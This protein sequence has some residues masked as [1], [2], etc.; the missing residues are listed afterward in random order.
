ML[1]F[2]GLLPSLDTDILGFVPIILERSG[3]VDIGTGGGVLSV[4]LLLQASD[5]KLG[6]EGIVGPISDRNLMGGIVVGGRRLAYAGG[7]GASD[8][9]A[10]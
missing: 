2:A 10:L 8:V 7:G 9:G 1:W 3:L 6:R 5:E 4:P